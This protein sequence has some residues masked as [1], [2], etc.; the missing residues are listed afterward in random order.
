MDELLFSIGLLLAAALLVWL[1][2]RRRKSA[3]AGYADDTVR[4][5]STTTMKIVHVEKSER[6]FWEEHDGQRERTFETVYNPTYEYTVDG[7]T[8]TYYS[9]QCVSGPRDLGRCVPGYYDPKNPKCITENRPRKP[10]F[11]GGLFFFG[12]AICVFAAVGLFR[13][14]MWMYF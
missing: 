5:S 3:F 2:I 4:Y 1:G 8:Y 6:E 11:G 14:V 12:A 13:S 7:K 9:F 10:V